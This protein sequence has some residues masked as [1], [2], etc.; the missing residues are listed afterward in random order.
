MNRFLCIAVATGLL[1]TSALA[2]DEGLYPEPSAPDASFVRIYAGPTENVSVDGGRPLD[3]AANGLTPYTEILPGSVIIRIGPSEHAI[4]AGARTHYTFVPPSSGGEGILL[5]DP[6][7][8]TPG[9]ADLLF[10]NFTEIE[11]VDLFVP[12]A[13]VVALAPVAAGDGAGVALRAPMTLGFMARSD[14]QGIAEASAVAMRP[15][16]GTSLVLMGSAGSY[17]LR[18]AANIYGE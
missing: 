11:A 3:P 12:A 16:T 9:E 5:T 2:Q 7:T 13:A 1:A 4:Q 14:G 10:Y 8:N 17:T 6:V 18:A 15:R